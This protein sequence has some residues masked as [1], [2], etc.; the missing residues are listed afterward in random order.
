MVFSSLTFLLIF[1]PVVLAGYFILPKGC[2]NVWLVIASLFFYASGEPRFVFLFMAEIIWNWLL[3]LV[4][5]SSRSIVTRKLS[6]VLC[7]AG[8]LA[9]LGVFKY[10]DFFAE[11][12]SSLTHT[13]MT[14]PGLTLPIGFSFYTFQAISYAVDIYRGESPQ[15][16]PL[17][18]ALYLALF[19]QLIAG[20]IVRY[21]D[22]SPQLLDR[23]VSFDSAGEGFM[24]F[25]CGLCK[26]VL[27]ANNLGIVAD[28][29]FK[30]CDKSMLPAPVLWLGVLSYTLQIFFDFSGYSDMAIGL[31]R[32][33]GFTI[34]ENFRDP[35]LA[36]SGTDFWRRWHI[37]LSSW[38]RDYVYIP[39]G[40]SRRGNA[41][42]IRNL[43]IVWALTG[44]WHGAGWTYILWGLL[45]GAL[46]ITE[47][48]IIKPEEKSHMFRTVY[49][50]LL[51]L[52]IVLMWTLFRAED[53]ETAIFIITGLF[54]PGRWLLSSGKGPLLSLWFTQA[55]PWLIFGAFLSSSVPEAVKSRLENG[56]FR[57]YMT[58]AYACVLFLMVILSLSFL[59]NGSYNPFLYFQF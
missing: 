39:L 40:G 11:T 48:F 24:R 33:F 22:I 16:N 8:D 14:G 21:S 12:I 30:Y 31:G 7:I 28:F 34:P 9:V 4:I 43:V 57:E 53:I 51:L 41:V 47:R 27:L 23:P 59:I 6:L 42:T 44:L 52:W 20:P 17:L 37:S 58:P 55:A 19:P 29:V 49:R 50:I 1:L 45:W 26:K 35:Y 36:V 32:V 46:L 10:A 13:Q 38:F 2:R 15:K 25:C 18:V 5:G 54:S 3:G 56:N